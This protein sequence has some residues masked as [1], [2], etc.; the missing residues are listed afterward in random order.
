MNPDQPPPAVAS[1][2]S[3]LPWGRL[4]F[5]FLATRVFI[6]VLGWA[7]TYVIMPG[8]AEHA[9]TWAGLMQHWDA[10]WYLEIAREGYHPPGRT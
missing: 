2:P 3:P 1:L 7:S 5:W 8:F 4:V 9:R 10:N 6:L